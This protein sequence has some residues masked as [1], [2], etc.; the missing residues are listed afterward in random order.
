M[1][2]KPLFWMSLLLAVLSFSVRWITAWIN[3]AE[4]VLA[5][6][7]LGIPWF[8]VLG[9]SVHKYGRSA[10]WILVGAPLVLYWPVMFGWAV[11]GCIFG[12]ANC[13]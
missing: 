4:Y 11:C 2:Y 7:A 8:V 1:S 6:A 13:T 10:Y 5:G 9:V 3:P 12:N